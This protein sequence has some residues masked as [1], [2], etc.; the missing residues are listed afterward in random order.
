MC[1]QVNKLKMI[2]S[3]LIV[4]FLLLGLAVSEPTEKEVVT[5][6]GGWQI[7]SQALTPVSHLEEQLLELEMTRRDLSL[8]LN[9]VERDSVAFEN[10]R[11]QLE[12]ID[13]EIVTI[14]QQMNQV[15]ATFNHESLAVGYL[16]AFDDDFDGL[17]MGSYELQY[18][19]FLPYFEAPPVR[20]SDAEIAALSEAVL[21][22]ETVITTNAQLNLFLTR[23]AADPI[24]GPAGDSGH[25]RLGA[26]VTA[27]TGRL[28]GRPGV[29]TG[30][31]DGGDF[32]ITGLRLG[33]A[34][35]TAVNGVGFIQEAGDGAVI[36]HVNF[37][38]TGTTDAARAAHF[39]AASNRGVG[40]VIGTTVGIG[41]IVTIDDVH[42]IGH[43]QMVQTVGNSSDGSW[44]GMVGRVADGTT[45]NMRDVSIGNVEFSASG[46]TA[47]INAVGGFVG[48]VGSASGSGGILNIT[49]SNGNSSNWVDV[50]MRGST[51]GNVT[52]AAATT[53]G[54][55]TSGVHTTSGPNLGGGVLGFVFSGH[56]NIENTGVVSLRNAADPIRVRQQAGGIV[57]GG[58]VR[59]TIRLE[60]VENHAEVQ[61]VMSGGENT[62]N[63]RVGGLVGRVAGTLHIY[64]S[65]NHGLVRHQ[66][67]NPAMGGLL[68]YS[69]TS[70]IVVID[71]SRN[72]GALR[73]QHIGSSTAAGA[74]HERNLNPAAAMGGIV[75]RSRG[76][77]TITNTVNAATNTSQH[78][79]T[80]GLPDNTSGQ[81][82]AAVNALREQGGFVDKTT[83]G[84]IR[85]GSNTRI[86][87]IVGRVHPVNGQ[88]VILN[89]VT[90][91]AAVR[92]GPAGGA[93]RGS[94]GGI[95]GEIMPPPRGSATI[96]L[97]N[98]TN[99]GTITG[100]TEAGGIIG[101]ARP[102]NITIHEATN[103]GNLVRAGGTSP[104]NTR[105]FPV[106]AGGIVGRAGG[107]N[108]RINQVR[109]EGHINDMATPLADATFG[110][111]H[112]GG[113][114]GRHT[115]RDLRINEAYNRGNVRA[116]HNAGGMI[117]WVNG[118]DA[119]INGAI[120][121]GEVYAARNGGQA[122]SGGIV[123][124]SGS[125][126]TLIRN[127]GN[128]GT[129]RMRG[130]NNN[131]D[132]VAGILGRS[133]GAGAR[134]EVSFNQG[135]VS[136][137]NSAGGIVGRNQGTLN[138]TDVYNIG[139]VHNG[140][141]TG[142]NE[143]AGNGILGRRR[144]GSVNITRAWISARVGGYAVATA[145][146]GNRVQASNAPVT[147]IRFAGVFVDE[148]AF[149]STGSGMTAANPA[150]QR[151]RNGISV[152]DTELLSSGYLPSFNSGPWRIGIAG[153]DTEY[154]R[155]Y[156]Y[157]HWQIPGEATQ[158]K[159][160]FTF[161]RSW[162]P[163]EEVVAAEAESMPVLDEEISE[164]EPLNRLNAEALVDLLEQ[165]ELMES[166]TD[167]QVEVEL[168]IAELVELLE[169]V[170]LVERIEPESDEDDELLDITALMALLLEVELTD[171]L[172]AEALVALFER[173]EPLE[174]EVMTL[175]ELLE[176]VDLIEL[177][178]DEAAEEARED[179]EQEEPDEP[180]EVEA[181][182]FDEREGYRWRPVMDLPLL[183]GTHAIDFNFSC[184]FVDEFELDFACEPLS[185]S[186]T[187]VFNTYIANGFTAIPEGVDEHE[188][189]LT[190][191][192]DTSIGLI[193]SNGVVGFEAKDVVGRI[194]IRGYDPLFGENPNDYINHT[195]FEIVS[196]DADEVNLNHQ[197]FD[198]SVEVY[199]CPADQLVDTM[200][201]IGVI[202]FVV[203]D[204]H[205]EQI[206]EGL[207][208]RL[209]PAYTPNSASSESHVTASLEAYTVVR[210]T[211]LGYRPAYRIIYT[212][213]LNHLSTAVISVPME[214]VP[215]PIRVWVPQTSDEEDEGIDEPD[216]APALMPGP[217]GTAGNV[218]PPLNARAGFPVRA[219][220]TPG[221]FLALDPSLKHVS[222]TPGHNF[223]TG[224]PHTSTVETGN[225]YPSGH[226]EVQHA[227]W[228]DTF[229]A[230]AP[231]HTTNTLASL[232]F[233][234]LINRMAGTVLTAN[235]IGSSVYEPILD[236]DLYVENL[237]LPIMYFRFVEITGIDE[238]GDMTFRNLSIDGTNA[239]GAGVMPIIELDI[240][241]EPHHSETRINTNTAVHHPVYPITN[242]T[243][244]GASTIIRNQAETLGELAT[245]TPHIR[246][247]GLAEDTTF[248]VTDLSG[249]FVPALGLEV[250]DFLRWFEPLV[251]IDEARSD[252]L[253]QLFTFANE[254]TTAG[255]RD[256][257]LLQLEDAIESG[258]RGDPHLIQTL[259]IP[260]VRLRE[261]E[262]RIVERMAPDNYVIIEHAT[263]VHNENELN[264]HAGRLGTF[265]MRDEG[266][267]ILEADAAG[268]YPHEINAYTGILD[269]LLV[270]DSVGNS[271]IRIVLEPRFLDVTFDLQGGVGEADFQ[272]VTMRHGASVLRPVEDPT[273]AGYRFEGWFTAP[274]DGAAFDFET[275]LTADTTLYARWVS[276][277]D[278]EF[279]KMDNLLYTH[280]EEATPLSG[281]RFNLY[282]LE[283]G[284][285]VLL[286]ADVES[287]EDGLVRF[288]GLPSGNS[289]RLRETVA[290]VGFRLPKG[291]D[292]AGEAG[293]WYIEIAIDRT[294][295][296]TRRLDEDGNPY[297]DVEFLLHD[298][299]WLVGNRLIELT[300]FTFFK[301]DEQIYTNFE[302]AL[303]L[304]G[305][306][307]EIHRYEGGEWLLVH[308]E[309]SD[310]NGL[311]EFLVLM[312]DST[313]RLIE[314]DAPDGHQIPRGHWLLEID[315][316]GEVT[317]TA[318][319]DFVPAFRSYD[320]VYFLG[321]MT[322]FELPILGGIGV[323]KLLVLIGLLVMLVA[324]CTLLFI[325]MRRRNLTV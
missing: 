275:S 249:E 168:E 51:R 254:G 131:A 199:P 57:G 134:I 112:A 162:Q 38:N 72:E 307:F 172:E 108:L 223:G 325:R 14:N 83:V 152:V 227:M 143:R 274:A 260:L 117:G 193:S 183:A 170:A 237:G 267:N 47:I 230:T 150:T 73:N 296:I 176:E 180:V 2:L 297:E 285:W 142:Q 149:Q 56:V 288:G 271:Y 90:N 147:G 29:F 309:T 314:V 166:A 151:N 139:W 190:R 234:H 123:G 61:V 277:V 13:N 273:R 141:A 195:R 88:V 116:L 55:A 220:H 171:L 155:T 313:Y 222:H 262:V 308:T 169:D 295:M 130:G 200:R 91:F 18:E 20:M 276:V 135:T 133:H 25:F 41:A 104:T 316:A 241:N 248:S 251:N 8:T 245:P 256:A 261:V 154:Q 301:M 43:Q 278:F 324:S 210:I 42:I 173:D 213:D 247:E 75:G 280:F 226:F 93:A 129:V 242:T 289:F 160:F 290:P 235:I 101:W 221:S 284:A 270:T 53:A 54:Q 211:A 40:M 153:V 263:L 19:P 48:S 311:V 158:Q 174:V 161:I 232:R 238:D 95:F 80:I 109:N 264:P 239:A 70:A 71:G 132:G 102:A 244:T 165:E 204:N 16:T 60:N 257:R 231:Q 148:T 306:V 12:L 224:T 21:V 184:D 291:H 22:N 65:R 298:E 89:N 319:G 31:F 266:F 198:C 282:I 64:N 26:N 32:T 33:A 250:A 305:A 287:D 259:I 92:S 219:D 114:I 212:G 4:S 3:A 157:F 269:E 6:E 197:F 69:G 310:E 81:N 300:S 125:R 163:F 286:E 177:L 28:A 94:V 118:R 15:W 299:A 136:G 268:F 186:R 233:E 9:Q 119:M 67:T 322:E 201:G 189:S 303:F 191:V 87:G 185:R 179:A 59:G 58:N 312:L 124:R 79:R 100:G 82:T 194:I 181:F 293:D 137:R 265:T 216:Y 218:I 214:R 84:T 178:D 76:R 77:L 52:P 113:I 110:T 86:G 156:P 121:R 63:G 17:D 225:A 120:N 7:D 23:P 145:Q 294:V 258:E 46:A 126:N 208:P 188:I 128:F 85:Q 78:I 24:F 96:T 140:T 302:D 49:T 34:A 97:T 315:E 68:G 292:P 320:G 111:L 253:G 202:H 127:A 192:G 98:V 107:A 62:T 209:G 66:N 106:D 30:I 37:T 187:R 11:A 272:A 159:P 252:Q 44:G 74:H 5:E 321:N 45:L 50:D 228:G 317:I 36:R 323:N 246:V 283:A 105:D 217:P 304:E 279:T 39:T 146:S 122:T 138:I 35:T 255:A 229:T 205:P 167:E 243:G 206:I 182:N 236:L 318:E 27:P 203:D 207:S 281:A 240:H 103:R 115:G 175:V 215:F 196:S 1:K 10:M 144:T 99:E 164:A